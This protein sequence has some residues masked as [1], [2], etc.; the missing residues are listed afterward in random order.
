[1]KRNLAIGAICVALALTAGGCNDKESDSGSTDASGTETS[2]SDDS[3]DSQEAGSGSAASSGNLARIKEA[4]T[5]KIGTKFD[6]PGF[7]LKG[8]SGSPEGFDVEVAKIIAD[9]MGISEDK[10]E[11]VESPSKLREEHITTGKADF[12]VATYTINDKRKERVSFAGPY[13][14]AGQQLMV[15]A[16]N[17]SITEPAD[18][19]KD[20]KPKVCSV[21]GSTPAETIKEYLMD[22]SQLVLFDVYDRCVDAL[23]QGQ[24][25]AVTTDNVIL[26]GYVSKSDGAFKLVGEQFTKEPYGIGIPKGDVELC[27]FIN[28]TLTEKKDAYNTAWSETAGKIEGTEAAVLPEFEACE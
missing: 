21:S 11:W 27:E 28:T 24:V 7:G 26:M 12:V 14:E 2:T 8:L 16:D 13:Y 6:Q 19:G 17:T 5:V 23:K 15:K 25:D 10:I 3:A 22:D 20:D 18:L 4:G 1:M 9:G